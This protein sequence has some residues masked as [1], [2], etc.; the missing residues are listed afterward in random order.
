MEKI[1]IINLE[2]DKLRKNDMEL[3]MKKHNIL[4]YNFFTATDGYN[5]D[6]DNIN[7][8]IISDAGLNQILN[9]EQRY[10]LTLTPGGAGLYYS[11]YHIIDTYKDEDDIIIFEDDI[12]LSENFVAD[13]KAAYEN[14]PDNYDVLYLGSHSRQNINNVDDNLNAHE[15]IKLNDIQINGTFSMILSKKGREKIKQYCF[16]A[17]DTQIDTVLY[18]NF[19]KINCYHINKSI[20]FF[21]ENTYESNIQ[22][23]TNVFTSLFKDLEI[24]ILICNKDFAMGM[25]SIQSLLAFNEFK[26]VKIYY[27]DDGSLSPVQTQILKDQNFN[28]FNKDEVFDTIQNKIKQYEFCSKYRCMNKPYSFWH[29]IKLFDYFLLSKTKRIL[30]LDTDILFMNKPENIIKLIKERKSFY[31]PDCSSSYCFNGIVNTHLE[32]VLYNV[33]TGIMYIDNESDY[34]INLIEEG[35]RHIIINDVNYFP[36]WIEQSAFAYMFSKLKKYTC[37]NI[38]NYKFPYFHSFD[39]NAIEA[40]HFVSYP[41]CRDMWK[42]YV[43]ILNFKHLKPSSLIDS[44]ETNVIFNLINPIHKDSRHIVDYN[45][46][47]GLNI[48][49]YNLN[50]E[51]IQISFEWNLPEGKKLSHI[52][53]INDSEHCYGSEKNGTFYIL[54]N[55][56]PIHV[57][58]TYEWYGNMNWQF[59]KIIN[60]NGL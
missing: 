56:E 10:G 43:D 22:T 49:I 33:N 3:E 25:E 6:Y 27:H 4:N 55:K 42:Q 31:M 53:K 15:F 19:D 24:H 58:H 60:T 45:T 1:I 17:N 2:K 41:P 32:G 29:K 35:L 38:N 21:K 51:Y 46:L 23:N 39:V 16:P 40:L 8:S 37:L 44:I 54:K 13:L 50:V 5:L 59:I 18:L 48:K 28:V 26:N 36:S 52:F 30:G 34:D 14:K 7:K 11:L 9:K 12:S 57:Y 20:A 47:I